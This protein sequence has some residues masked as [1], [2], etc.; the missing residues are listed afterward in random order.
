MDQLANND[1]PSTGIISDDVFE[2]LRMITES[3]CA[4]VDGR[5][6]PS[7]SGGGAAAA[8]RKGDA[9]EEYNAFEGETSLNDGEGADEFLAELEEAER[10]DQKQEEQEEQE[11]HQQ[12]QKVDQTK[13]DKKKEKKAK[14]LAKK[15]KKEAKRK[16]KEMENVGAGN[17]DRKRVKA[18]N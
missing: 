2:R 16:A 9:T 11:P 5:K 14:K 1:R 8:S 6:L 13:R 15:A 4:E 10:L 18:E 7:V 12:K 17:T 3:I